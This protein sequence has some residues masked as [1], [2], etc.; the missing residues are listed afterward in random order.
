LRIFINDRQTDWAKWLKIAQFL[1]KIKQLLAT[2]KAPFEVTRLYLPRMGVEPGKSKNKATGN[3]AKDMKSVLDEMGKALFKTAEQM[4]DRAERRCSKA[5]D[6]KVG[7][8]VWLDTDHLKLKDW[9]SRKLT[10]KWIG[11]YRIKE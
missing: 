4:K 7:N 11:P 2:G 5:P 10:K 1:Y 8:L 3:M 9:Q 6:Y